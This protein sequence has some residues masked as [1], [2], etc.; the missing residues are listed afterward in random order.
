LQEGKK[1]CRKPFQIRRK[2]KSIAESRSKS[3]GR[4]KSI[5]ETFLQVR[6][7]VSA[8]QKAVPNSQEGK[9]TALEYKY[10]TRRY[11]AP[12]GPMRQFPNKNAT[13]V[14]RMASSEL[15][16]T[17]SYNGVTTLPNDIVYIA[18]SNGI[19]NCSATVTRNMLF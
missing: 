9:G 15:P 17:N 11:L 18:H 7:K 12:E 3:A 19:V 2:E 1:G 13:T 4:K 8:M 14:T 5:A 16:L 10:R 6:R